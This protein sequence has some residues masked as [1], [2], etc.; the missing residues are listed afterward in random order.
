MDGLT[1]EYSKRLGVLTGA[2][3]QAACDRFALG[4][5]RAATSAHGGLF[6]QNVML[7]TD[8]GG[9]V[10]RGAPHYDGQFEKE[11]CFSRLIAERTSARAPWPFHIEKAP[12]IFGWS[13]AVMPRLPGRS[14]ADPGVR[15]ALTPDDRLALADALGRHLALLHETAWE[16]PHLF[17]HKAGDLVPMPEPFA[18]W[19]ARELRAW[20]ARC[21]AASPRTTQADVEWVESIVAAGLP[22]LGT[23][24]RPVIVHTDYAEGNV[25]V[26]PRDGGGWDVIG[27]FDLGDAHIGDGE[28]DL[29]RLVCLYQRDTE[30]IRSFLKP[31]V[32]AHP[33]RPGFRERMAMHILLDRLIIW[34]YGQRNNLWFTPERYPTLRSYAE[35]LVALADVTATISPTGDQ[36]S[37]TNS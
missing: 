37:T 7:E 1:R 16:R 31:Y 10:L 9:W 26:E 14:L 36:P 19:Y 3:L 12:E 17:D 22:S 15:A 13:Y 32:R 30:L 20:L 6:G 34:E 21:R 35:P 25:V 24:F 28:L 8:T 18:A 5:L 2:Q 11:A 33:P 29:A 4:K 27:V 23:T